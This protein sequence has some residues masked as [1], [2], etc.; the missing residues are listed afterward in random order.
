M[1]NLRSYV[2][3]HTAAPPLVFLAMLLLVGIFNSNYLGPFG[4]SIVG[5]TA[6]PILLVPYYQH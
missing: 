1:K 3:W 2:A 5:A 6:A 4:I